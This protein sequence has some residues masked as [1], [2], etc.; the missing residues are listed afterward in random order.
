[1]TIIE[2]VCD[3]CRDLIGYTN[4]RI[5]QVTGKYLNSSKL[6]TDQKFAFMVRKKFT[7][8]KSCYDIEIEKAKK[9]LRAEI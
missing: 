6:T 8:C 2:I 5:P 7:Y 3:K 1:M 9:E 4:K